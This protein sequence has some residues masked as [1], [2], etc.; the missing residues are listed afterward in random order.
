MLHICFCTGNEAVLVAV[1]K[2]GDHVQEEICSHMEVQDNDSIEEQANDTT[3]EGNSDG[4]EEE[5][6]FGV[7]NDT[8]HDVWEGTNYSTEEVVGEANNGM[9]EEGILSMMADGSTNQIWFSPPPP[10]LCSSFS[11]H[12]Y[13]FVVSHMMLTG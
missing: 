13:A 1:G 7:I 12:S 10:P 6:N 8:S 9:E 3:D 11:S 5:A 2:G 4:E